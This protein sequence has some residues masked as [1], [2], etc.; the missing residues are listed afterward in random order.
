MRDIFPVDEA[1]KKIQTGTSCY[2]KK[3]IVYALSRSN[4]GVY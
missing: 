2:Y 3:S 4:Y 1:S